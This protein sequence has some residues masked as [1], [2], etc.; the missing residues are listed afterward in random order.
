MEQEQ[1]HYKWKNYWDNAVSEKKWYR[2][3]KKKKKYPWPHEKTPKVK[4]TR[5]HAR[6][7]VT[8]RQRIGL[9][10]YALDFGKHKGKTLDL[11]PP[12]YLKWLLTIDKLSDDFRA[13]CYKILFGQDN[14]MTNGDNYII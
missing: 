8:E 4:R 14:P 6:E 5:T 2:Q 11:V 12:S 1:A 3:Q 10:P 9:S 13:E 7:V